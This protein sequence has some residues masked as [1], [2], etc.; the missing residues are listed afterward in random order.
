[1]KNQ[2]VHLHGLAQ[3]TEQEWHDA[4]AQDVEDNGDWY[5]AQNHLNR[6]ILQDGKDWLLLARRAHTHVE[7]GEYKEASADYATADKST[8]IPRHPSKMVRMSQLPMSP[9]RPTTIP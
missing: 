5:D 4:R 2:P 7:L 6:L 8:L 3:P 1:M 9:S